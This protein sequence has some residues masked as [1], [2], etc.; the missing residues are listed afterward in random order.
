MKLFYPV[1]IHEDSTIE[2]GPLDCYAIEILGVAKDGGDIVTDC[3]R[4]VDVAKCVNEVLG[5]EFVEYQLDNRDFP[6]PTVVEEEGVIYIKVN[7]PFEF[8]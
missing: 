8:N 2:D 7:D 5:L 3:F 6:Q 1:K 4:L